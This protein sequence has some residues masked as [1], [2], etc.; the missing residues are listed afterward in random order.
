MRAMSVTVGRRLL[1]LRIS[2][3]RRVSARWRSSCEPL[4]GAQQARRAAMS[5]LIRARAASSRYLAT[6]RRAKRGSRP[7]ASQSEGR[8]FP[9]RGRLHTAGEPAE[10]PP[11][12]P[13]RPDRRTRSRSRG[14]RTAGWARPPLAHL[15]DRER[16][17]TEGRAPDQTKPSEDIRRDLGHRLGSSSI[18]EQRRARIRAALA[19]IQRGSQDRPACRTPRSALG[20]VISAREPWSWG[21]ST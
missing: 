13:D 12:G 11:P 3:P 8:T 17:P 2:R 4:A 10:G 15:L 6:L 18:F 21:C 16:G 14:R 5:A 9:A 7:P 19:S 20:S 1:R